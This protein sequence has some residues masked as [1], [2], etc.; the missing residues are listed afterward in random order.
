M[1]QLKSKIRQFFVDKNRTDVPHII[2][3]DGTVY[4]HS[5]SNSLSTALEDEEEEKWMAL[6]IMTGIEFF[7]CNGNVIPKDIMEVVEDYINE[8]EQDEDDYY[9]IFQF[10]LD[11]DMYR[12]EAKRGSEFKLD[13][14]EYNVFDDYDAD[15]AFEESMKC[16]IDEC[17]LSEIPEQYRY[18]FDEENFIKDTQRNDGRGP[19]LATYDGEELEAYV[20]EKFYY[21]Y[22]TD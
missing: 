5:D 1:H 20:N 6:C 8:N 13:G 22:R 15:K 14:R 21:G 7:V 9:D 12:E 16:Y 2:I 3:K 4:I 18:Y 11:N 19:S 10:I 17:V